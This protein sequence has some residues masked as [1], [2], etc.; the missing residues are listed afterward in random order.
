MNWWVQGILQPGWHRRLCTQAYARHMPRGTPIHRLN[1]SQPLSLPVL[2]PT[3]KGRPV[4]RASFLS[5][6]C[7]SAATGVRAISP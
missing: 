2:N 4:V 1:H 3:E 5:V 6:V 7:Q